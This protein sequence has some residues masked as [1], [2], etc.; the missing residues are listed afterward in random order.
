MLGGLLA[1]CGSSSAAGPQATVRSFLVSWTHRDW[2]A[3]SRLVNHPPADFAKVNVVALFDLGVTKASYVAGLVTER[4]EM[5]ND[6]VTEDLDVA[7][8]GQWV[9][10]TTLHLKDRSGHWLVEWSPATID[11]A[12]TS[13]AHFAVETTWAPRAPILGAG[14]AP[15]T[16]RAP[17]V[18]IGVEGSYVTDPTSLTAALTSAG[19]SAQEVSE[20][21][22]AA[23][24]NPAWFEPVFTV[25]KARYLELKPTLYPIP[26]T[27]FQ[28]VSARAAI[29]PG[30]EAHVVGSVG[31]ITAQEVHALGPPYD[32]SSVVGQT[33]LEQVYESQLAGTPGATI[34]V[35]GANGTTEATL[36]TI[37]SK[38]GKAL[39]TSIDPAVQKAAEA[40]LA[41]EPKNAA[42]VAVRAS[43]G[44]V[45]ASV[46]DPNTDDFD[47]AL[48]GAF[49][50]GSTFKT[51][52]STALIDG[53]LSPASAASC[54]T[55]ITVGGE[56][57]HNAEGEASVENLAQAFTESC[58]TAFIGLATSH[59]ST[60]SLPAAAALY[61]IGKTP[62]MGLAAFGGQV[63]TPT[64]QADLAATAIGQGQVLVS[65]LDMA[66]VAAAID[67]GTVREP[68]LVVGAP[69][70]RA[71]T[72][73]LSKALVNDLHAMMANVV[74]RGTAANEGLPPGTYAKTGTAQYGTGN[75]LPTDAWLIGFNRDIAFAVLVVDGG[76]GGPTDG[77]IVAKFL[78]A[79]GQAK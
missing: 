3:M 13:G 32:A 67:T 24:A 6:P 7:A 78:D 71:P 48:D 16:T 5:A 57:F 2:A 29:T 19:A 51:I 17:M 44:Q 49:P 45:L 42:L 65:P 64:D 14:G 61:D 10:H 79:L 63:P 18:I 30:L 22:T 21:L 27:V 1:G 58:N 9:V 62:A 69:D 55:S 8:I 23:K 52:T 41:G 43:T 72:H 12:L 20:A 36:A 68:R 26:G 73:T 53:G 31:P 60:P 15:L 75:P 74:A 76:N 56:V 33:G 54:P 40:A 35:V 59:L 66:M 47:Q 28:A 37:A 39:E 70:D 11:P 46:S 34:T 4:A 50:P 25:T 38:P 77:P